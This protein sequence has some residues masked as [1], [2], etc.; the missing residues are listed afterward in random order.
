MNYVS[1]VYGVVFF[2]IAVDWF[3]RGRRS[4]KNAEYSETKVEVLDESSE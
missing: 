1:A 3:A 4:F 2:I